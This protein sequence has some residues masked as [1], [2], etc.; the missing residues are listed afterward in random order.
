MM[1]ESFRH[2][3]SGPASFGEQEEYLEFQYYFLLALMLSTALLTG[4]FVLA[5]RTDVNVIPA[6]HVWANTLFCVLSLLLAAVL[7]GRKAWVLPIA[8]IYECA[9]LL[10]NVSAFL[11][12]PNDELRVIWMFT[13]LAGV[14]SLLGRRAGVVITG[15]TLVQLLLCNHYTSA[16]LSAN[17]LVTGIMGLLYLSLFFYVY[18]GRL[19]SYFSRL[20]A[21]NARLHELASHDALTGVF[22]ARAYYNLCD[23]AIRLSARMASPFSVL[24]VDLDHFKR[25]NDTHGHAAGDIVLKSVAQCLQDCIRRS[26]LLGRI[27]G[28]EFSVFLPDTGQAG[29]MLVAETLRREIESLMPVL[30]AGAVQITAS[31]GVASSTE[32]D[33]LTGTMQRIQQHADQA[34]YQAK[35]Q[36]RNRVSC[37]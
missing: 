22:N 11:L 10:I 13:N 1:I 29:A 26:D 2:L 36:G 35:A 17:A 31:I 14:Y 21:S 15:V 18:S 9:S 3:L 5:A 25:I 23:R 12:V 19:M 37:F 28:E 16:P 30:P 6:G 34:M 24:F 27:G 20:Q 32:T 8:W 7:R 33:R 4:L